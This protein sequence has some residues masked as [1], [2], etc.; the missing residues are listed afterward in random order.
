MTR[1][2]PHRNHIVSSLLMGERVYSILQCKI[3]ITL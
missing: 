1:I 3:Q 2:F